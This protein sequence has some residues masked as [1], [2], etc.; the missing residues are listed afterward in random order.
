MSSA[1]GRLCGLAK[2]DYPLSTR[3]QVGYVCLR[4][5]A[6]RLG[7]RLLRHRLA[8]TPL[9]HLRYHEDSHPVKETP[10]MSS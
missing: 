6:D 2:I 3:I 5:H 7:L 1:L 10:K 8:M 9:S 4:E